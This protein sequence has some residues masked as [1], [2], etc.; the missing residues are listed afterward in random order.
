[1]KPFV[2]FESGTWAVTEMGMRRLG[3]WERKILRSIY[4]QVVEQGVWR[5]RIKQ[6]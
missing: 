6:E 4:G 5:R 1:M 3:T 2:V